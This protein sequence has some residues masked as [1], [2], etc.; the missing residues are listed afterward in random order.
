MI[1][2]RETFTQVAVTTINR[3]IWSYL[4]ALLSSHLL[5]HFIHWF[6]CVE[7]IARGHGNEWQVPDPSLGGVVCCSWGSTRCWLVIG[8][9]RFST[10]DPIF[11]KITIVSSSC[12][13]MPELAPLTFSFKELMSRETVKMHDFIVIFLDQPGRAWG[14]WCSHVT[15]NGK[16]DLWGHMSWYF[17]VK[18]L[19][20]ER[21]SEVSV[22]ECVCCPSL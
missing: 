8:P 4:K 2:S 17:H 21:L 19:L 7:L 5:F 18:V 12:F 11:H 9:Q 22:T 20:R 15:S 6:F 1:I 16:Q 3:F 14:I 13:C 10:A